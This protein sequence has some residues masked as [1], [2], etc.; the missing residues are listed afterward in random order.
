MSRIVFNIRLISWMKNGISYTFKLILLAVYYMKQLYGN[1]AGLKASQ[2]RLLRNLYSRN[3]PVESVITQEIARDISIISREIRRQTGLLIN[4]RGKILWV[5]VGDHQ[6][7]VI[8]DTPEYRTLQGGLKGL[9]CVHTHLQDEPLTSDDLTDLALLRLDLMAAITVNSR[10]LPDLAHIAYI[11]PLNRSGELYNIFEPLPVNQLDIGCLELIQSLEAELDPVKHFHDTEN[12]KERCLLV[13]ASTTA[14]QIAKDSLV[15]LRQLAESAGLEVVDTIL[16]HRKKAAPQ[17]LMGQGKLR[18]LT[19]RALQHGVTLVIFD[20]EL[21]PSQI[22]SI[23]GRIDIKIIDRTQ[24]ILDIFAQRAKTREGKLQVELAQ[25]RYLLPRLITK[26]TAMSRLTGGIGGRGPGE[27]KLEINRRRVRTRIARLEKDVQAIRKQ[28]K[29]QR[30]RRN[31][32]GLPVISVIGYTNAGKSTLLNTLTNSHVH[33]ESRMF[34]TLDPSSRRLRFPENFEV[35]ITDTVGFIRRIPENL[36]AAFRA[37]FEE[38]ESA[39]LL[40]H[41]IDIS[42]P[43]FNEQISSVE[44]ILEDLNLTRIPCIRV[45][46]KQ[47]VADPDIVAEQSKRLDGTAISAVNRSTLIPLIEKIKEFVEISALR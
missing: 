39:N 33:A 11:M 10:G 37:T 44:H 8:P 25:L 28:R 16:Q 9:R 40:L 14:R 29:Q 34:A 32:K 42:N 20:Q 23:T 41:V 17:F 35:I 38:L 46:N 24:L 45:L 13:S 6:R 36:M 5:I 7:I 18:D 47:D 43:D 3:V 21:S 1:I 19:I 31:K 26:N 30:S 27:T 2:I 22:R 12:L 15:E 4:R